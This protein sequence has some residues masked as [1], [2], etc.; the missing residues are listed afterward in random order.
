MAQSSYRVRHWD[1][2]LRPDE[3]LHFQRTYQY[4]DPGVSYFKWMYIRCP[5]TMEVIFI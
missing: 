3:L 2:C 4:E 1:Y 5:N